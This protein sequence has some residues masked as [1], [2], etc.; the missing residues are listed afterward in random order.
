MAKRKPK[1]TIFIA[2]EGT[3]TEPLY[4]ENIK[5]IE[6]DRDDYPFSITI[7]PD[8]ECDVNPKTDA[9]GLV[10]VA[11]DAKSE[12]N[13]VWVVFDKDGYTK[14]KE[15]FELARNNEV[16]IAFSSIS[17]ETWILFHFERNQ[18][19][20]LKSAN[21]INDKFINNNNYMVEYNKTG[22]FN[23]YPYVS[24]HINTAYKNAAWIRKINV[25]ENIFDNNPYT[26]V[27]LLVKR[28]TLND[29]INCYLRLNEIVVIDNIQF[30]FTLEENVVLMNINNNS[31]KSFVTNSLHISTNEHKVISIPN[32]LIQVNEEKKV[33]IC[34][35]ENSQNIFVQVD[36]QL[37]EVD[38]TVQL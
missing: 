16:N 7:Y 31:N 4:F 20:F 3:N 12:Y 29:L 6:E 22:E 5:E 28:L 38:C 30:Q 33:E 1:H 10:K 35:L 17:F 11:I 27:D 34:R 36:N 25:S 23:V 15:A 32:K 8:R 37:I 21:I 18:T 9:L 14:H 19:Q 26:D 24:D 2:C 13:E